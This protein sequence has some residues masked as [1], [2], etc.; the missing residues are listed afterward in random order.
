ML[1]RL[2]LSDGDQGRPLPPPLEPG[3]EQSMD[4]NP[5]VANH[6]QAGY[7]ASMVRVYLL[8]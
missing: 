1:L 6:V 3:I 8:I 2:L 4:L 7:I 5:S